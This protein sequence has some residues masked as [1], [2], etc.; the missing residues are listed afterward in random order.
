MACQSCKI[1]ECARLFTD[2]IQ[3]FRD[4][5]YDRGLNPAEATNFLSSKTRT[6]TLGPTKFFTQKFQG[7]VSP[8]VKQS[9]LETENSPQSCADVK[10]FTVVLLHNLSRNYP[11]GQ[12]PRTAKNRFDITTCHRLFFSKLPITFGDCCD[13]Q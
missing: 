3:R 12:G 7:D 1:F 6:P 13:W 2:A 11:H 9:G 10:K 8:G 5:L 4:R